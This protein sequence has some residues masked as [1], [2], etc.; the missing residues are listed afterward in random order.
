VSGNGEPGKRRGSGVPL[1]A[2]EREILGDLAGGASGEQIAATL[3]LSPETVRTH[4]RNAMAKLGASSRTHA[5]ALALRRGEIDDADRPGSGDASPNGE[6]ER[7]VGA[8]LRALGGLASFKWRDEL[9]IVLARLVSLYDVETASVFLTDEDGMSLHQVARVNEQGE[10]DNLTLET[11]VLGKGVLGHAALE[12]RTQ[13]VHSSRTRGGEDA[14]ASVFAPM[15]AAGRLVGAICL[16]VRSS[17]F[18]SRG[19]LLLLH[20]FGNRVGEILLRPGNPR[21]K[22][23]RAL[24]RFEMSWVRADAYA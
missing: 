17:R 15:V 22:L 9:T 21:R 6:S 3:V 10:L 4:I 1:S 20:A 7:S 16:T 11:I 12:R 5:V 8:R 24:D 19:E 13:V 23:E 18:I 2:R 14:N